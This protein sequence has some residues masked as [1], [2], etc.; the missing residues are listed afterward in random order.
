MR[1]QLT[2][3]AGQRLRLK[4]RATIRAQGGS[5]WKHYFLLYRSEAV[6]QIA[7][8]DRKAGDY[9]GAKLLVLVQDDALVFIE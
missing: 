7:D 9:V 4:R 8:A 1:E 5:C 3:R 6:E 2:R